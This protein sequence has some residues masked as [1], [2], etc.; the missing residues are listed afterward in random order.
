M[1]L[2]CKGTCAPVAPPFIGQGDSAPVMHPRS[3]VPGYR[4]F[5]PDDQILNVADSIKKRK[6]YRVIEFLAF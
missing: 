2:V 3:G 6:N 1:I 4:F 5:L